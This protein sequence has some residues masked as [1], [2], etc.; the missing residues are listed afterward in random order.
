MIIE[1]RWNDLNCQSNVNKR[2]KYRYEY[3]HY[4]RKTTHCRKTPYA[5]KGNI[6]IQFTN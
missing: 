4:N 1:Y 6:T 2:D 5:V 3:S